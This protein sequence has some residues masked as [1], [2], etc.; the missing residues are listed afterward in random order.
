I[1]VLAIITGILIPTVIIRQDKS[2]SIS[3]T[4]TTRT[5]TN[6]TTKVTTTTITLTTG[7]TPTTTTEKGLIK[8]V[9]KNK[10]NGIFNTTIGGNSMKSTP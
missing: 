4:T 1:V 5:I 3:I 6:T 2:Q 8:L 7:T 10:V 9:V